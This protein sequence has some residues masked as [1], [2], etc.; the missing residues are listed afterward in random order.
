MNKRGEEKIYII[1]HKN[2]DSDSI[3]SAIG[4]A[5]YKNKIDKYNI[6]VPA[7]AGNL[8]SETRFILKK[9]NT[10]EPETIENLKPTVSDFNLKSP[11]VS[12]E[13][14][15]LKE[16][17]DLMKKYEI[18]LVPLLNREGKPIGIV[19]QSAIAR[20]FVERIGRIDLRETPVEVNTLSTVLKGKILSMG[21]K[22]I[23]GKVYIGANSKERIIKKIKKGDILLIG[24]RLDIVS[25]ILDKEPGA[26]ILTGSPYIPLN[27][28]KD[29]S[30][31]KITLISTPFDTYSTSKMIDLSIQAKKYMRTD[32]E[33]VFLYDPVEEVKEKIL[34]SRYRGVL[35][36]DF[37]GRL[38]GI[39]TRTDL[40]NFKR[41]KVIL[42][43]HNELSQ[44]VDGIEEADIIEV[45]DHHRIG[46]VSTLKPILFHVEPIG[47][48]STL[49]AEFYLKRK[50]KIPEKIAGILLGGILSDT[51]NLTISTTTKR[52]RRI[53]K[54]LSKLL[55]INPD[56]FARE[57]I[58]ANNDFQKLKPDEIIRKDFKI[59]TIGN[60]KIG[61][62]QI[63]SG[64]FTPLYARK[65]EIFKEMKFLKEKGDFT[66]ICLMLSNPFRGFSEIWTWGDKEIIKK[67]F[68]VEEKE[69]NIFILDGVLSRKKDFIVKLG[70]IIIEG[71]KK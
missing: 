42:V 11:V 34:H 14:S 61:I 40:I 23:D 27:L 15:S 60:S 43:D 63:I 29:A 66:I 26:I 44:A 7:K 64:D 57:I 71:R 19:P 21:K 28:I 9:F 51:M 5:D 47:S 6:Y 2:P 48:T 18:R 10:K 4:Y 49:V 54:Y 35:V 36:I 32:F 17:V 53:V 24:D 12:S 58:E 37:S 39:L 68:L 46:D 52:D 70:E 1:G 45:I 65:N 41:K 62:G 67:A 3:C 25:E 8:N 20:G 16:V 13:E 56:N 55:N 22:I 31:K 38:V 33:K 30:K 69:K 59:F 50:I